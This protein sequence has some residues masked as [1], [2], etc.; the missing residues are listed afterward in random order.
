M[1]TLSGALTI[2]REY[3]SGG[4]YKT[5]SAEDIALGGYVRKNTEKAAV[6]LT[7]TEVTN[8][9]AVFGGRN[10]YCGSSS[11][12]YFHGFGEESKK[13]SKA[14]K[15]AYGGSYE[16]M[17]DF[18]RDNGISY[19]YVGDDEK[20]EFDINEQMLSNLDKIYENGNNSLYKV[21]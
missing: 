9:I 15:K 14:A 1:G 5:F 17:L 13:R 10:I 8:P 7:G 16:E 12:V 18:C 11:Y 4:E 6:F 2:I 21:K 20:R 19:V 3:I